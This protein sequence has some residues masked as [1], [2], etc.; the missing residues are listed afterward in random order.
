M[1]S[2]PPPLAALDIPRERCRTFALA[3]SWEASARQFLDNI[4]AV[5][6]DQQRNGRMTLRRCADRTALL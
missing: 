6:G 4:L 2:V 1:T 5:H 3:Y